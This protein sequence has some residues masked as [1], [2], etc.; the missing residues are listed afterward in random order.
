[1][2]SGVSR[3][4]LLLYRGAGQGKKKKGKK[5][6]AVHFCRAGVPSFAIGKYVCKRPFAMS[7]VHLQPG[8]D[9]FFSI[10]IVLHESN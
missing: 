4:R 2:C 9:V 8:E 10:E 6:S 3:P 5:V 1:M 7:W